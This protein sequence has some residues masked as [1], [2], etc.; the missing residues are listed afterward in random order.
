M[1][2]PLAQVCDLLRPGLWCIEQEMNIPARLNVDLV[3]DYSND[4]ILLRVGG[5]SHLLFWRAEIDD[6]LYKAEFGPR[7]R[8]L[9]EGVEDAAHPSC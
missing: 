8:K 3:I 9:L 4:S 1:P 2:A 6:N 7:V 5:E